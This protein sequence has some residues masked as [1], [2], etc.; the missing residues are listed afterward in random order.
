[1]DLQYSVLFDYSYEIMTRC[2]QAEP[3]ERPTFEE[4]YELLHSMLMDNEV[5]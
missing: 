2:W 4:I 1:M 5:N 3:T